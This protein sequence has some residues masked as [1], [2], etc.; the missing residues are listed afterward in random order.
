MT[1]SPWAGGQGRRFDLLLKGGH[2]IDPAQGINGVCDVAIQGGRVA[3]VDANIPADSAARVIDLAGRHVTPGLID[4]HTHLYKT[5]K[6]R[7]LDPDVVCLPTGV[8]ACV[9]PGTAGS[10]TFDGMKALLKGYRSRTWCF[11]HLSRIG[12]VGLTRSVAVQVGELSNLLYADPD[13]AIAVIQG[14]PGLVLG[15]KVRLTE[16]N[17]GKMGPIALWMATRVARET[18]SQ[19]MVHIG[20]ATMPLAEITEQLRPGDIVTHCFTGRSRGVLDGKR[21]LIPDI[22]KAAERGIIFDVGHGRESFS[23]PVAEAALAQGFLPNTIST[24][25]TP[26]TLPVVRDLPTTMAKFLELGLSL[27]QVVERTTANAA[28]A[29]HRESEIGALRPGMVADVAAFEIIEGRFELVDSFGETMAARRRLEP[30][31]TVLDGEI[32]HEAASLASGMPDASPTG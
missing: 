1:N 3:A 12:L 15:V 25:L 9:D 2:L 18:G 28:R 29:I 26:L 7:G 27:Y 30:V 8:T 10:I 6:N 5:F 22:V 23:F 17:V 11:V 32:V 14:N 20:D 16:R 31:L 4:L 24:D 19:V 21:R 13:G